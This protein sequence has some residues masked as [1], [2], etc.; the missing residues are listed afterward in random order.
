MQI[1]LEGSVAEIAAYIAFLNAGPRPRPV[2]FDDGDITA[3]PRPRPAGDCPA[4]SFPDDISARD[5]VKATILAMLA[6][7]PLTSKEIRERSGLK[8]QSVSGGLA[9][10][11]QEKVVGRAE[12]AD[13]VFVY[14]LPN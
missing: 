11:F 2:P 4:P 8:R 10:M 3:A 5:T 14:H 1:S 9:R 6:S 12:N 7:E 13:G